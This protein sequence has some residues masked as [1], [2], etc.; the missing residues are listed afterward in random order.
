M[1]LEEEIS[2]FLKSAEKPA[3]EEERKKKSLELLRLERK[4][5]HFTLHR[6]YGKRVLE[7]A[8]YISP[9]AWVFQ[10]ILVLVLGMI[11]NDPYI[12]KDGVLASLAVCAPI[13]GVIGFTEILRSYQRNMWELEQ[14]CR[15][16][17]RQLAGMRLL[18]FGIADFLAVAVVVAGGISNGFQ[19]EELLLF[20]LIPQ[21]LSDCVYLYLMARFRRR[22]Q[23]TVLLGAAVGIAFCWTQTALVLLD[24]Q[25]LRARLC[26]PG[27]LSV[28]LAVSLGLLAICCIRFLHGIGKGEE[29]RWSFGWTD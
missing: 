9:A 13:V 23:G 19:A 29:E 24:H 17:L 15:Y 10:G 6:S 21:L 27:M 11:L 8:A 20:F 2:V 12:V 3:I 4:N 5:M 22:F 26:S 16:N 18:I 1:R 7:Q 25:E 28:C 14:A